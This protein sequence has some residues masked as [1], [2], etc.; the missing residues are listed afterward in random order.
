M[1]KVKSP[2]KSL[3]GWEFGK[4][5]KGNYSTLKELIKV[6]LPLAIGWATSHNP[7]LVGLI[8]ILGKLA[9]DT[10]EYWYKEY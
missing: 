1:K 8:T 7:A 6:G 3:K 2:K 4:W 9:M 10:L 5:V